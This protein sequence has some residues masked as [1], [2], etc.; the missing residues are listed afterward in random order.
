MTSPA[1][2][3]QPSPRR[4][5]TLTLTA[6]SLALPYS[7]R[8]QH[9]T[10]SS[11]PLS[12]ARYSAVASENES[13]SF[14]C[15][16]PT[17]ISSCHHVPST[18]GHLTPPSTLASAPYRIHLSPLDRM[19][20]HQRNRDSREDAIGHLHIDGFCLSTHRVFPSFDDDDRSLTA[21]TP[22]FLD[23]ALPFGS[24]RNLSRGAPRARSILSSH[25]LTF[26]VS[27]NSVAGKRHMLH[28]SQDSK[29]LP[30]EA[31]CC[32]IKVEIVALGSQR[33][34]S[35]KLVCLASRKCRAG[36]GFGC[37][38]TLGTL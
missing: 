27:C 35:H 10:N 38:P 33:H 37:R 4:M 36:L 15:T 26:L 1:I 3:W 22:R 18:T 29:A 6:P 5:A 9:Y 34:E 11:R 7:S 2:N 19:T 12:S 17:D 8:R 23:A 28:S 20:L 24:H 31:H 16:G 21:F 30:L 13:S 25:T 14:L 32:G